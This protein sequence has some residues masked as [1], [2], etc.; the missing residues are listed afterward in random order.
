MWLPSSGL[1]PPATSWATCWHHL[2]RGYW[3][4]PRP[5]MSV[6][7]G[8][9]WLSVLAL[10]V[11]AERAMRR[12]TGTGRPAMV[13]RMWLVG[14]AAA[15]SFAALRLGSILLRSP[16]PIGDALRWAAEHLRVSALHPDPNAAGSYFAVAL[17]AALVIGLRQRSIWV[18][19][20]VTPLVG[21]AFLLAGSRAAMGA[22]VVVFG[23]RALRR[24]RPERRW[25]VAGL[26]LVIGGA[27]LAGVW[28][29]TAR[30]H[31]RVS[32]A[33]E[34]RVQMTRVAWRM[35]RH[36]PVFGV[37]I[38]DYVRAS[39][40]FM[41]PDMALLLRFAPEGE[42]AH[43]N[44]LQVGAELGLP[45]LAAFLWL[46]LPVPLSVWWS[47]SARPVSVYQEGLAAG[48]AAFLVSAVLG[49]PLLI[50][51]VAAAFFLT[52]GLAAGLMPGPVRGLEF[53]RRVATGA[54][55]FFCAS[56][57]WRLW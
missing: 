48:L 3:V 24:A 4:D 57:I 1:H 51:Q 42:N 18:L 12:A 27:V 33:V 43:D 10:A 41:T 39:R 22:V 7:D 23:A 47:R 29:M 30:S 9:H 34:V 50:F 28:V 45:A 13:V 56:L 20:G 49:H 8:L 11:F 6:H 16:M 17:V 19:V 32:A 46:V 37:G 15:A 35:I 53:G 38:G 2:T 44:F 40:R 36:D 5:F 31:A 26:A 52:L 55:G 21:L 25:L 14:G 54:A